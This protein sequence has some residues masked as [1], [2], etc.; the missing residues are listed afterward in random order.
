MTRSMEPR[1]EARVVAA[2]RGWRWLLEGYGL[3]RRSPALWLALTIAIALMWVVSFLIPVVGPLLFNLLSPALFA[4]LMIGCRA[5]ENG[6]PLEFAHLFAGFRSHAAPLVTVGGVYLVGT[7]VVVGI[8][9]VIA[10]GSMPAA[11]LSKPGADVETLRAVARSM[12]LAFAVGAALYLPVLMLVWFAPMLV[13]FN[14]VTPVAAMKLSLA[15]CIGNTVPFLVYGAAMLL[16][17]IVISL[18]AALGPVGSVLVIALFVAS[19]PVL[20]CS[21]YTSYRD[22]F[23]ARA[24]NT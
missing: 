14:G 18:P 3:F 7:V 24:S 13:V 9:L 5:L 21:V 22:I 4:G 12:M 8:V 6:K 11:V 2:G 17:T 23:T 1:V 20:I 15:A 19:I 16:A 10:G